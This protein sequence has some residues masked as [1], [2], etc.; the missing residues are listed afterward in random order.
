MAAH[1]PEVLN[2]VAANVRALRK[3]RGLTQEELAEKAELDERR[4]QRI[5]RAE[6][7]VGIVAL[8]MLA[9]AL[10]V[11]PGRLFKPADFVA[12]RPGRP[13]KRSRATRTKKS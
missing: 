11:P 7:D 2:R 5:E 8:A 3:R 4:V 12:P 13:R 10:D 6:V 1:T 9:H